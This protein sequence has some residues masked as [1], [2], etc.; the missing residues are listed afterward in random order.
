MSEKSDHELLGGVV[1]GMS[2]TATELEVAESFF[3]QLNYDFRNAGFEE[4]LKNPKWH[5]PFR[6]DSLPTAD[7]IVTPF[8]VSLGVFL[9]T[10]VGGWAVGKVCDFVWAKAKN[11]VAKLKKE[12]SALCKE[13]SDGTHPMTF[14]FETYYDNDSFSILVVCIAIRPDDLETIEELIPKAQH[15]AL[16]WIETHGVPRTAL[17]YTVKNGE[18]SEYPKTLTT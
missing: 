10:P 14:E 8:L 17:Q 11:A 6:R 3:S 18:L 13:S 2:G 16:S 1:A 12:Y 5:R 9:N 7:I 4:Q 15:R